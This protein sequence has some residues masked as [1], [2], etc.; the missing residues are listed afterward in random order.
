MPS[1]AD[2][3][4]PASPLADPLSYPGHS[5]DGN[6]LWLDTWLYDLH[7]GGDSVGAALDDR[8]GPGRW[9]VGV[10]GGPLT[11]AG[12]TA[13]TAGT[14][15]DDALAQLGASAPADRH[16]VLAFGSNGSPAQL[17][18]KF[19]SLDRAHRVVPVLRGSID[20]LALSHSPHVSPA[21]YV[22][23]VLVRSDRSTALRVFV[24]WLD[25]VQLEVLNR[26]EPNYTLSVVEG[27]PV[28]VESGVTVPRYRAYRGNWGALRWNPGTEP[29][30]AATQ[31]QVFEMLCRAPWFAR[32][33]GEG[34]PAAVVGRLCNDPE[35][36]RR[37]RDE[38]AAR[39]FAVDD[40]LGAAEMTRP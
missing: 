1:V 37:V 18:A 30:A 29:V 12:T 27:Y 23:W 38:L 9:R 40:G 35:L 31:R 22:P 4:L 15:L 21:G 6:Y 34:G 24:L 26:T 33:V 28:T 14:G 20:G 25:D 8:T 32:L 39:G 2:L 11:S 19:A 13:G 7:L 10:D 3:R 17:Q 5:I 16:P 36:R